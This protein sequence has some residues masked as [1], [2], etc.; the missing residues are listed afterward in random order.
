MPN[1]STCTNRN[2]PPVGEPPPD[3]EQVPWA[4]A[5]SQDRFERA[6]HVLAWSCDC[7]PVTYE[8]VTAGGL[9]WVRRTDQ[10]DPADPSSRV[11]VESPS[12]GLEEEVSALWKRLIEGTAR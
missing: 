9:F 8:K 6:P 2:C 1:K 11:I 4:P 3:H 10:L 7:Q 5:T 12:T